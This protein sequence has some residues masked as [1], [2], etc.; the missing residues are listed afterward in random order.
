MLIGKKTAKTISW[1]KTENVHNPLFSLFVLVLLSKS[2]LN[3]Q[4]KK[5]ME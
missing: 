5:K 3:I 1:T 4:S 2:S